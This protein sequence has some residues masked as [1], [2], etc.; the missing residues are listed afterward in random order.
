MPS[1]AEMTASYDRKRVIESRTCVVQSHIALDGKLRFINTTSNP[2][3][4]NSKPATVDVRVTQV[5]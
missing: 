4:A 5:P 1:G 2:V 3:I